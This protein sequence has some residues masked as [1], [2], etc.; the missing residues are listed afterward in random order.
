MRRVHLVFCAGYNFGRFETC[1]FSGT[2]LFSGLDA[3][4][5]LSQRFE[6]GPSAR[7]RASLEDEVASFAFD[8]VIGCVPADG[9][10]RVRI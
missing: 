1:G 4:I 9:V 5:G 8:P 7:L 6:I 2:A 3:R 10:L